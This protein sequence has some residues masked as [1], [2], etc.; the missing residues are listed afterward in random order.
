MLPHK[1]HFRVSLT[2]TLGLILL[3]ISW[4]EVWNLTIIESVMVMKIRKFPGISDRIQE[5]QQQTNGREISEGF[6]ILV[7]ALEKLLRQR[8]A[9]SKK[10][11]PHVP[12]DLTKP[13]NVT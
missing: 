7:F 6:S 2:M 13:I 4:C 5:F 11:T 3:A 10:F 12:N 1:H 8:K 9:K